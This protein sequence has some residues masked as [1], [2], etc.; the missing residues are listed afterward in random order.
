MDAILHFFHKHEQNLL[1]GLADPEGDIKR[2]NLEQMTRG[3]RGWRVLFKALRSTHPHWLPSTDH[4]ASIK[5]LLKTSE[6]LA[7][8]YVLADTL[9]ETEVVSGMEL[10]YLHQYTLNLAVDIEKSLKINLSCFD[11]QFPGQYGNYL[12]DQLNGGDSSK[13]N[14]QL[15]D[16]T[17]KKVNKALKRVR[18]KKGKIKFLKLRRN[19][20]DA[21]Y[22]LDMIGF[23]GSVHQLR[24]A[25]LFLELWYN[26]EVCLGVIDSYRRDYPGQACRYKGTLEILEDY[27][28]TKGG[29]I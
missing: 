8:L 20:I 6:H 17:F 16:I 12:A 24:N 9:K 29:I 2:E 23:E 1:T 18:K 15:A 21:I 4:Q 22:L 28:Q 11:S 25:S 3:L 5:E 10:S 26:R 27:M 19:L 14:A 13:L 7:D